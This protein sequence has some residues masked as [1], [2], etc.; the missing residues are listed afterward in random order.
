MD[1]LELNQALDPPQDILSSKSLVLISAPVEAAPGEWKKRAEEMQAFFGE[2]GIDA[3]AYFNLN[4][5]FTIPGFEAEVPKIIADRKITNLIFLIVGDEEQESIIGFGP[6]NGKPGLYDRSTPFW[7]RSFTDMETVF[8]E[9]SL[10]FKTGAFPRTNLLVNDS[11]EF[12][13]FTRPPFTA[14]YASFPPELGKK[15]IGIP[16]LRSQSAAPGAQLLTANVF[17]D[18][19]EPG[20]TFE[21]RNGAL[22]AVVLD[23]LMEMRRIDLTGT[24]E[25][26][27]RRDGVTHLLYYVAGDSE[28]VYNLFRFKGREDVPASFLVK[29]FLKDLRNQN[30]FLGRS[31]DANSDWQSA[32][33]SFMAQIEKELVNQAN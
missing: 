18:S 16:M 29:F 1:K 27:L 4:R 22:G 10:R 7:A 32:L 2:A 25:A 14:N 15:I 20:L 6:Y 26:L 9:M 8:E 19:A 17:D 13:D 33:D 11:P 23:S 24:T 3:V 31:W 21:E 12:F 28:Y 5:K 30:I